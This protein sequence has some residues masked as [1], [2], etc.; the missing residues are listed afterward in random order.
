MSAPTR[1]ATRTILAALALSAAA[2][3]APA[4]SP[5]PTAG[6]EAASS[7]TPYA[8]HI[9]V[10]GTRSPQTATLL[11]VIGTVVPTTLGLVLASSDDSGSEVGAI[12]FSYGVYFGPATG[13]LY[14]GSAG[15][16]LA[17]V[18]VRAGISLLGTGL[19]AAAC[20]DGNCGWGFE[21]PAVA[22]GLIT[23][24][25]L[26]ASMIYDMVSVDNTV[27]KRNEALAAEH[28]SR[29]VAV[30]PV[31]SPADGGTVG[32]QGTVRF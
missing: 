11:S 8:G 23:L 13:Y 15:R 25:G 9:E 18:G 1:I 31:L 16:G 27:R 6:Y 24:G 14:G 5:A 20:S 2:A 3:S 30:T 22:V 21:G 12:L 26:A 19:M 28:W 17:G 7:G 29:R 32:L 4:Q 10:P